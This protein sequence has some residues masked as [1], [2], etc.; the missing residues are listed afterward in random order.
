MI[1]MLL[2]NLPLLNKLNQEF[3]KL[4]RSFEFLKL[5][6]IHLLLSQFY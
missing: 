3:Y 5:N 4:Q 1:Q 6:L 2:Q